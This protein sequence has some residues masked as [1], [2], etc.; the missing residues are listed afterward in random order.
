MKIRARRPQ[1]NSIVCWAHTHR[2]ELLEDSPQWIYDPHIHGWCTATQNWVLFD[3]FQQDYRLHD[4]R[5]FTE[6]VFSTDVVFPRQQPP[7]KFGIQILGEADG[8]YSALGAARWIRYDHSL[9]MICIEEN[10][11]LLKYHHDGQFWMLL[12]VIPEGP[13]RFDRVVLQVIHGRGQ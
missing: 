10:T 9:Q 4:G 1:E 5:P 6:L 2:W 3:A 7:K 12:E 13:L 11:L 8:R